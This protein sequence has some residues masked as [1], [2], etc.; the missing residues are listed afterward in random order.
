MLIAD[1]LINGF[2]SSNL[3][4][5]GIVIVQLL[6]S[7]VMVATI[8][9]KS[10]ELGFVGRTT[11]RFLRDFSMCRDVLHLQGDVREAAEAAYAGRALASRR[12]P[13]RRRGCCAYGTRDR[14][15]ARNVRACP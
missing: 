10:K 13:D 6:A 9:G 15:G 2:L 1:S 12:A 5:Q 11:R 7:V 3:M 8:I 14:A 4:G